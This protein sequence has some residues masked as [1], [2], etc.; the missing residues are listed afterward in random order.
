[1]KVHYKDRELIE[2][3]GDVFEKYVVEETEDV[4]FRRDAVEFWSMQSDGRAVNRCV[5]YRDVCYISDVD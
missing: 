4:L 1:M 3:T 2:K 5:L